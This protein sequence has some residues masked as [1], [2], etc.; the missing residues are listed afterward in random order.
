MREEGWRIFDDFKIG[1]DKLKF[2]TSPRFHDLIDVL[3]RQHKCAV[4]DIDFCDMDARR[5]AESDLRAEVPGLEPLWLFFENN[6]AACELNIRSRNRECL[7]EEL[8]Y[9]RRYS[10]FYQIPDGAVTLPICGKSATGARHL[11]T[12]TCS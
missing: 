5:E 12:G 6:P 3:R 7:E 2:R 4:A 9:L 1:T 11:A 8:G 10:P